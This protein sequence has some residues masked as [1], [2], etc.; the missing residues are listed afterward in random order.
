M[1]LATMHDRTMALLTRQLELLEEKVAAKNLYDEDLAN[2]AAN[3]ARGVATLTAEVRKREAH[4]KR[5]VGEMS[6]EERLQ[7][8]K[9]YIMGLTKERLKQFKD[10]IKEL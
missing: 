9:A 3:L 5:M 1:D 7:L 8:V 6:E 4:A 10:F 2:M